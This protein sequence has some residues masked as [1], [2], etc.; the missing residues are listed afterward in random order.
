MPYIS[1]HQSQANPCKAAPSRKKEGG[2]GRKRLS[3]VNTC[4][5]VPAW[6]VYV[7]RSLYSSRTRQCI[8][9]PKITCDNTHGTQYRTKHQ[10]WLWQTSQQPVSSECKWW[11]MAMHMQK[12]ACVLYTFATLPRKYTMLAYS[13]MPLLAVPFPYSRLRRHSEGNSTAH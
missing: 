8:L 6:P 9:T 4:T 12:L 2:G 7:G 1:L 13:C 11:T 10:N 3:L 5:L